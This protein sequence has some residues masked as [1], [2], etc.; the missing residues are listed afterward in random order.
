MTSTNRREQL[1]YGSKFEGLGFK[2]SAGV[3]QGNLVFVSGA[4][5][6]GVDGRVPRDLVGDTAGQTRMTL[7]M[8]EG[9]LGQADASL[10][11]G[12][13]FTV[14]L[15]HADDFPQMNGVW[16]DIFEDVPSPSR[17]TVEA[18]LMDPELLVEINAIAMLGEVIA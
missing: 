7:E 6:L 18:G 10:A 5:A 15:R 1:S 3:K 2:M 4:A 14:F 13:M 16:T 11:D 17:T 12:V 8:I 9:V